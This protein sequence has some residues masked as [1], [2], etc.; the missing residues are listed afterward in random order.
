M[1][2]YILN[3]CFFIITGCVSSMPNTTTSSS[4]KTISS[5]TGINGMW[6]GNV[7]KSFGV[8]QRVL[9]EFKQNGDT[10]TGTCIWGEISTPILNGKITGKKIT[11]RTEMEEN[12]YPVKSYYEGTVNGDKL[13]ITCHANFGL[14]G[15]KREF[16]T[17]MKKNNE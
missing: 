10:L 4:V 2:I 9:F 7:D 16:F 6:K 15:G 11:F 8:Y 5:H 17:Y 12:G 3:L 14:H 13:A 1:R